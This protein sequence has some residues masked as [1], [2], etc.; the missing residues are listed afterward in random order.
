MLLPRLHP[1]TA[2][3]RPPPHCGLDPGR[4]TDL[5]NLTLSAVTTTPT[6]SKKAGPAASTLTAYP[7]GH[8]PTGSTKTNDPTPTPA[9]NATT[10]NANSTAA[11]DNED[12]PRHKQHRESRVQAGLTVTER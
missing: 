11:T 3:V 8:H 1:P 10:P 5:N 9:S 6:S 4:L 7:N 12:L 2:M